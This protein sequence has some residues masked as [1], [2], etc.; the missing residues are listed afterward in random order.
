MKISW[1]FKRQ[2]RTAC[3]HGPSL[4]NLVHRTVLK[5]GSFAEE[6]SIFGTSAGFTPD[7]ESYD[8]SAAHARPADGFHTNGF[9]MNATAAVQ[10]TQSGFSDFQSFSLGRACLLTS[11]SSGPCYVAID[12]LDPTQVYTFWKSQE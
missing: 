7:Y 2:S 4:S 5:V 11:D 6:G 9:L 8:L 10:F 12:N 1:L 3:L